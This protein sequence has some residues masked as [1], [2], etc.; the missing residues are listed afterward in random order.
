MKLFVK[1][2]HS[3]INELQLESIFAVYGEIL[4]T[5]IIYD[6]AD[7]SSKGFGFIEFAKKA[8]ALKAIET[9]NGKELKGKKLEVKEAVEKKGRFDKID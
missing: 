8:D 4:S 9:L 3:D 1:N 7:W 5:K 6:R 2:I